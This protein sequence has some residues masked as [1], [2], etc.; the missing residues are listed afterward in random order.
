MFDLDRAIAE[1]RG[2]MLAAGIRTPV[3]LEELESH[4]REDVEQQISSGLNAQQ[5]FEAAVLRIGRA[6]ALKQEFT[7]VGET[8]EVLQRKLVWA[9][10]GVA[11]LSCW[12]EFGRS[13][14]VALVYGV[15]LA[16]L[17]VATFVD[18]K[19]FIIPDEI[20]MAASSGISLLVS[21]AANAGAKLLVAGM[22]QACSAS[23][24]AQDWCISFCARASWRL[25][26]RESHY[27]ATP[28]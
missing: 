7:K 15:L 9:L 19:H 23:V 12:I 8:K 27:R 10:I 2:Q 24:S 6:G 26:D 21:P 22:L 28:T 1:W 25:A 16:G 3:P 11:F 5:A 17:I 18:F 13:P 4:L 20:S 14:A